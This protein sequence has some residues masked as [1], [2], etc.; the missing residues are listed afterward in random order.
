VF[1]VVVLI[2]HQ[3]T[4]SGSVRGGSV[5]SS[6]VHSHSSSLYQSVHFQSLFQVFCS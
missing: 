4:L 3:K 2:W 1:S 5:S 6:V